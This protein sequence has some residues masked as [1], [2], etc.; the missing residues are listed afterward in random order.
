[1]RISSTADISQTDLDTLATEFCEHIPAVVDDSR[2]FYKSVET[3][4]WIVLF[5]D[6]QTWTQ[7][8]GPT[9]ALFFAELVKEAAK[10]TWRNRAAVGRTLARQVC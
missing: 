5:G 9:V 6:V 1:M 7:V 3:P 2:T 4:S 10:D 8:L